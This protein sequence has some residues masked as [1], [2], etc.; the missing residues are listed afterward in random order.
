[1]EEALIYRLGA[2]GRVHSSLALRSDNGLVFSNRH[3]TSTVRAYG[4]NQEY[5]TPYTPEQNGLVEGF[6]RSL[7]EECIWVHRFESLGP[8]LQRRTA[9]SVIRLCGTQSTPSISSVGCAGTW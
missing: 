5:T 2:L 8:V 4:L 1:M 7:K 6:F 9:T 3:Y